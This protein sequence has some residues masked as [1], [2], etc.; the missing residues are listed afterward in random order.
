MMHGVV[1]KLGITIGLGLE[2]G[3]APGCG[4]GD[5]GRGS[6]SASGVPVT[7]TVTV[8]ATDGGSGSGGSGPSGSG[9]SASVD[10]TAESGPVFDVGTMVDG[11][12]GK[13]CVPPDVL[14]VL[15]RS[16]SMHRTPAGDTPTNDMAGYQS[17]RWWIAI[18]A[19]EAFSVTFEAGIALGLELFPDSSP[20][21]CVTL[22]ERV[23]GTGATD[24]GCNTSELIFAPALGTAVDFDMALDPLTTLMCNQTPISTAIENAGPVLAGLAGPDHEQFVILLT[25]GGE[26][27]G[28]DFTA[29][30][31]ELVASTGALVYVVAF[32]DTA[33]TD[34]NDGLNRM[35]CAGQTALGF[36]APCVDDGMGNYDAADPAGPP[37]YIPAEDGQ[38]LVDAF[39]E[40]ATA[41]CCGASCPVG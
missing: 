30:V 29:R 16:Q 32:G 28:G 35:A 2:L 21:G 27:C 25:D 41:L 7:V 23:A 22:P 14:V 5:E 37:L 17:S 38:A 3:L 9:G 24:K 39:D 19:L 31:Q 12:P 34:E 4:G 6:E 33:L 10:G 15:D 26:S 1:G 13:D 8:T 36:P 18:E 40:I 20:V 11:S